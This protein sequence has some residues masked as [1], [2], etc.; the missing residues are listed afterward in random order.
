MPSTIVHTPRPGSSLTP[1]SGRLSD[2]ARAT[3]AASGCRLDRASRAA[4]AN[5]SGGT[6]AVLATR[7]SGNVRVPVLSNTTVSTSANRSIASPLLRITPLRN[8][9]AAATT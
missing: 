7:A 9:R 3:A 5:K 8:S 6:D 1:S 2:P 4:S